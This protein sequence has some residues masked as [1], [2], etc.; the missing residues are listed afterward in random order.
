MAAVTPVAAGAWAGLKAAEVTAGGAADR[1]AA[2][3]GTSPPAG[4]AVDKGM[5]DGERLPPKLEEGMMCLAA[6][7]S[8][9]IGGFWHNVGK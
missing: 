3:D 1:L 5:A 4:G 8:E 9:E 6:V 2:A 7:H